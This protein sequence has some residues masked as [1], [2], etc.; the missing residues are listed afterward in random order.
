MR[1]SKKKE[2]K[3][4]RRISNERREGES[5]SEERRA[6]GESGEGEAG[7]VPKTPPMRSYSTSN[8]LRRADSYADSCADSSCADSCADSASH[9]KDQLLWLRITYHSPGLLVSIFY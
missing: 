7:A 9:T 5:S 2:M 6:L 8:H 4:R 1:K 3:T